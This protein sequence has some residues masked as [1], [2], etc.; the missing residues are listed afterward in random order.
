LRVLIAGVSGRAAAASAARAGLDVTSLDAYADADAHP[1]VRALSVARDYRRRYSAPTAARIAR[2]I[3]CDAVAYLSNFENHAP[4]IEE[5]AAGRTL[6][7][8]APDVVRR[9]R[10]PKLLAEAFRRDGLPVPRLADVGQLARR[11]GHES[12]HWICKP[13]RSGGG[14]RVRVWNGRRLPAGCYLQERI[15]GAAR[16][17]VFVAA[18]GAAS[19]LGVSRQLIGERAFG[20]SQYRYCGNILEPVDERLWQCA[21]SLARSAVAEFGLVGVNGID[22]VERDGILYPIELNPRWSSSMELVERA[23]GVSMFGVH[24]DACLDGRVPPAPA[25]GGRAHGKAIVFAR[26][27][28]VAGDTRP[29]LE[30]PAV[31]D[32]PH[33]GDR[34]AAGDPVC[35]LFA[36]APAGESCVAALAARAASIYDDLGAWTGPGREVPQRGV[37]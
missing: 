3:E 29:W 1:A 24:A 6:L 21:E 22:C 30:D 16:S 28:V 4:A 8:N 7:G 2:A 10:D 20:V 14:R 13:I 18:R 34:I 26:E 12:G 33:P 9:V 27:P 35:T 37:L 5:L 11:P 19:V 31:A 17:V 25:G 32:V 36:A 15:D 23:S